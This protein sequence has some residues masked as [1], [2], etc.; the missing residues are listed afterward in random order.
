[1]YT[2]M[3]NDVNKCIFS[4]L[5]GHIFFLKYTNKTTVQLHHLL[6]TRNMRQTTV[7]H[8]WIMKMEA[9][10]M[11]LFFLITCSFCIST[12]MY[13]PVLGGL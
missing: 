10:Y 9:K 12:V 13:A 2:F 3:V 8:H 4:N 5:S 1:M 11:L 7:L 6:L